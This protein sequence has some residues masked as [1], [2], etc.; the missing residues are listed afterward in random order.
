MPSEVCRLLTIIQ[1]LLA[2]LFLQAKLLLYVE[3]KS[4]KS[5]RVDSIQ[6]TTAFYRF[7]MYMCLGSY[8]KKVLYNCINQ[9]Y[10]K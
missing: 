9:R 4:R 7:V 8:V 10:Y 3:V 1:M 5:F 6:G 2:C